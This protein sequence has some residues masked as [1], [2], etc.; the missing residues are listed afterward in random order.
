MESPTKIPLAYLQ[1]DMELHV[2]LEADLGTF[3]MDLHVKL[4]SESTGIYF[5]SCNIVIDIA[6]F[7]SNRLN[8][9]TEAWHGRFYN[10]RD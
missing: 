6:D 1:Y 7:F 8:D 5:I 2:L 9:E 3:L 10:E 4:S